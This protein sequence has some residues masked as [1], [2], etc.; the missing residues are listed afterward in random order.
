MTFINGYWVHKTDYEKKNEPGDSFTFNMRLNKEFAIRKPLLTNLVILLCWVFSCFF[1]GM[2][3]GWG[4][5]WTSVS[6]G[7]VIKAER[8][9]LILH[10]GEGFTRSRQSETFQA[11]KKR[12]QLYLAELSINN[13]AEWTLEQSHRWWREYGKFGSTYFKTSRKRTHSSSNFIKSLN[14]VAGNSLMLLSCNHLKERFN[15]IEGV[16][17]NYRFTTVAKGLLTAISRRKLFW[18][19][20]QCQMMNFE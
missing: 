17:L 10:F 7:T 1:G 11:Y 2:E 20:L 16:V 9:I 5:G 19:I 4:V 15:D 3:V 18:S 13:C 6:Q 8:L 12:L 14:I